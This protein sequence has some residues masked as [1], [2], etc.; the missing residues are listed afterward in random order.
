MHC[1]VGD[2]HPFLLNRNKRREK[3]SKQQKNED[4]DDDDDP[5]H[6]LHPG[7]PATQK[8]DLDTIYTILLFFFHKMLSRFRFVHLLLLFHIFIGAD[9]SMDFF[10]V[11]TRSRK[12]HIQHS[13]IFFYSLYIYMYSCVVIISS[14]V[15]SRSP[16]FFG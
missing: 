5:Q 6:C 9:N 2:S 8:I 4:N 13:I 3:R 12:S 7:I 15:L 1:I 11:R 14:Y 10:Y 16:L